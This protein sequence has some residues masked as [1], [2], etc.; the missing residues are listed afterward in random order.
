MDCGEPLQKGS[1]TCIYIHKYT[2]TLSVLPKEG[3]QPKQV[4]LTE[5]F[6]QSCLIKV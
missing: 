2:H 6:T 1:S 3:P 4:V 5:N